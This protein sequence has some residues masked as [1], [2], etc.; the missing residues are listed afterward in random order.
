MNNIRPGAPL[1]YN[2]LEDSQY[3]AGRNIKRSDP[4]LLLFTPL[5][6]EISPFHREKIIV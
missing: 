5:S 4:G 2:S 1:I 3:V 6:G